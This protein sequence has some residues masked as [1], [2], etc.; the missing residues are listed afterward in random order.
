MR[1]SDLKRRVPTAS[2]IDRFW[3]LAGRI[4]DDEPMRDQ[5]S[6]DDFLFLCS[7]A[8]AQQKSR[9]IELWIVD[10]LHAKPVPASLDRGDCHVDGEYIEIKVST[11]NAS[12]YLNI[13]QIRPWQELD[14]Y[15][16]A[17]I[18]ERRPQ[19]S[20]AFRLTRDQMKAEITV[21]GSVMHGTHAAVRAN[22]NKEYGMTIPVHNAMH[23]ITRRWMCDYYDSDLTGRIGG[24]VMA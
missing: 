12:G 6:R 5:C 18:E 1:I 2:D 3:E 20:V 7:F 4:S 24:G 13:R 15:I 11:T 21:I 10:L 23:P 19:R 22:V 14:W 16:C 9:E 17:Y 8:S